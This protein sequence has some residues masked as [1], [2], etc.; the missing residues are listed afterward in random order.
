MALTVEQSRLV[1]Q[2]AIQQF[3]MLGLVLM[4]NAGRGAA[5]F[6]TEHFSNQRNVLIL[7]GPGNNGGD[8][9]VIA[10]HL[11][12]RDVQVRVI[13]VGEPARRSSDCASNFDILRK[14]DVPLL[15]L[16]SPSLT[17]FQSEQIQQWMSNATLIAD[18][19]LGTGS[20]GNIREPMASLVAAANRANA[21][22][23]AIDVPTGFDCN[24]GRGADGTFC[25]HH[26]LTFVA[27]KTAFQSL[28]AS[29]WLGKVHVLPIGI[30][31]EVIAI[32][33]QHPSLSP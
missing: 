21:V 2:I 31:K 20:Q 30:P 23:I 1:D 13:L 14:T 33:M 9:L 4:E 18:A 15:E 10:R 5:D 7:C 25:A 11:Q 6:I 28:H 3:G 19:L 16:T 26:T 12:S 8:G 24:Q 32:A 22:R 29:P 27:T 17:P